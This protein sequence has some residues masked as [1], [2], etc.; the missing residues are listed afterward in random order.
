MPFFSWLFT[1]SGPE[2]DPNPI[3]FSNPSVSSFQM[4]KLYFCL[5]YYAIGTRCLIL[6]FLALPKR[7]RNPI[8]LQTQNA[9]NPKMMNLT[10]RYC[11]QFF[12]ISIVFANIFLLNKKLTLEMHSYWDKTNKKVMATLLQNLPFSKCPLKCLKQDVLEVNLQRL[13]LLI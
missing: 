2:L 8:F 10:Q 3:I 1:S 6:H 5:T 9:R 4:L 13:L 12:L 11:L 7:A